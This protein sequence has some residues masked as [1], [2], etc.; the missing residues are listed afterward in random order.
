M[1]ESSLVLTFF[2]FCG[3]LSY[4]KKQKS[5]DFYRENTVNNKKTVKRAALVYSLLY[6]LL[7]LIFYLPNY[8]PE[9]NEFVELSFKGPY[10]IIRGVLERLFQFF[11]PMSSAALLLALSKYRTRG[12]VIKYAV[13]LSLPAAVYS[14]PYCYLY[15]LSLGFDSIEGTGISFA[16]TVLG[17][18][19][20]WCHVMLLFALGSFI[21]AKRAKKRKDDA[22]VENDTYDVNTTERFTPALAFDFS[23][24]LFFGVLIISLCE[25]TYSTVIELVN[26]VSFFLD[27]GELYTVWGVVDTVSVYLFILAEMLVCH[28]I[29]SFMAWNAERGEENAE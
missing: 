6:F 2:S 29:A 20:Q 13:L 8:V 7:F 24:P 25:L 17:L 21:T 19:L 18:A 27:G 5:I 11:I 23:S 1:S 12:A 10:L 15:A 3:I 22:S 4:I 9:C 26:T 16:L 14:L 28:I